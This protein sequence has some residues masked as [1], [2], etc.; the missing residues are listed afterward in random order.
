H[1][2]TCASSANQRR[3]PLKCPLREGLSGSWIFTLL[4]RSSC[5]SDVSYWD[6]AE[7]S[8]NG[9]KSLCRKSWLSAWA[10]SPISSHSSYSSTVF[11]VFNFLRG[12]SDPKVSR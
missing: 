1:S 10:S 8:N 6:S 2:T 4:S 12:R 9:G 11:I 7:N 3:P 5:S